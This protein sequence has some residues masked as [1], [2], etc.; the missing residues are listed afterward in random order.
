[1]LNWDMN[2]LLSN[3]TPEQW[4]ST[5]SAVDP[6]L[7]IHNSNYEHQPHFISANAVEP[8]FNTTTNRSYL[9][10]QAHPLN[11]DL[12]QGQHWADPSPQQQHAISA[13]VAAL[14]SGTSTAGP[15][16]LSANESPRNSTGSVT[17]V[18]GQ[19]SLRKGPARDSTKRSISA[20]TSPSKSVTSVP[21]SHGLESTKS[22]RA[23]RQQHE[24]PPSKPLSSN[25]SGH[26]SPNLSQRGFDRKKPAPLPK[27]TVLN[28]IF[29]SDVAEAREEDE[30]RPN[31]FASSA[32]G[33]STV[34]SMS[35]Q[36]HSENP[37]SR[38]VGQDD[39]LA[40]TMSRP[41]KIEAG[42]TPGV[43]RAR[44][45][46]EADDGQHALPHTKGF[47]IQI[48]SELFKL[49]GASIMSDGQCHS[50]RSSGDS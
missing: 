44:P 22:H 1:M 39:E 40:S 49:S 12:H 3:P 8:H 50:R 14:L 30:I 16:Q 31:N 46:F 18:P 45:G 15:T 25:G 37:R 11:F 47:S 17:K 48:G 35:G 13:P 24:T 32:R 2:T 43:L 21:K 29:S 20:A 41:E 42:M 7:I 6:N 27:G 9:Y 33:D 5:P 23:K 19:A 28:R 36:S 10:G 26:G 4:F 38:S 34:S